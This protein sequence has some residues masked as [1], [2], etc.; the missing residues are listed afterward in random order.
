MATFGILRKS[1]GHRQPD[2]MDSPEKTVE[3]RKIILQVLQK[4]LFSQLLPPGNISCDH[5]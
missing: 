4:K 1:A 2:F 3:A 5:Y